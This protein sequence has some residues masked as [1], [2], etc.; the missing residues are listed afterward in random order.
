MRHIRHGDLVG[1]GI[2]LIAALQGLDWLPLK[3]AL[4]ACGI[5]LMNI[6]ELVIRETLAELPAY[7]TRHSLAWGIAHM[8]ESR[9]LALPSLS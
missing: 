2:V 1:P 7:A 5:P 8:L 6:P 4:Q 3:R 9:D